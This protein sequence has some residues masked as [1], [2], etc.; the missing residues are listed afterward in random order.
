MSNVSQQNNPPVAVSDLE[1]VVGRLPVTMTYLTGFESTYMPDHDKDVLET[2]R[3]LDLFHHDLTLVAESGLRVLRYPAPWHRIE[4][5]PGRYDW[6]WMDAAMRSMQ[7][8]GLDPII[9]PIHHTSFPAW[10]EQG[11]LDHRFVDAYVQF[12]L[13]FADRY[14]WVR[15]Y[16]PFNEPMPTTLFCADQGIWKPYERHERHWLRSARNVAIA[17]SRISRLL[18]AGN[19][20]IEI[21]HV[22]TCEA[23]HAMDEKSAPWARFLNERRF[24]LHDLILGRVKPGHK[25]YWFVEE[26]GLATEDG[27]SADDLAWLAENPARIDVLGLD[28]YAHSEQQFHR[29]GSYIPSLAP[30]GF[31]EVA[32]Q[33]IDYFN[34]PVML[35][36]TNIRGYVS[37]RLSWLKYMVEQAEQL[38]AMG[39][40]WR[41][42]CWFPFVDSTDW[43][44]LLRCACNHLDPVGIYWLDDARERHVSELSE[45]YAALAQGRITASDIPAY[46]F[47]EPVRSQLE[48]FMSQMQHWEWQDP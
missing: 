13:A 48:G 36:E 5:E 42:F 16:T 30:Y 44:S 46:R 12:V 1:L 14:P 34:L 21:V 33:Y 38:V 10:L 15:R 24:L 47:Q 37:D 23:H 45:V 17:V 20:Q 26:H 35:T 11:F 22:D 41:G 18:K 27:L 4:R 28:Y 9:D 43:D 32:R 3:H 19:P 40:D 6:S 2:T 8:L 7:D 39:V 29:A 31:A 25:L